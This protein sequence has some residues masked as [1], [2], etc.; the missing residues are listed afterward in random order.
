MERHV[1]ELYDWVQKNNGAAPEMRCAILD[2]VSWLPGE[3]AVPARRTL[4][5]KRVETKG[6]S[7]SR[8]VSDDGEPS[9]NE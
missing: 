2:V 8:M 9:W 7:A 1:P 5:R 4:Q 3:R 6:D